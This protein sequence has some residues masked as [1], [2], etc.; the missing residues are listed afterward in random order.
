M[1][2]YH[3]IQRGFGIPYRNYK[4]SAKS[5][6]NDPYLHLAQLSY[7]GFQFEPAHILFYRGIWTHVNLDSNTN[8]LYL[9]TTVKYDFILASSL[10]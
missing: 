7:A 8:H 1:D 6:K 2:L 5:A 3:V 10:C 9:L 4:I